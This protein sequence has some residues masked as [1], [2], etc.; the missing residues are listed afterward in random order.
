MASTAADFVANHSRR[1]NANGR[2]LGLLGGWLAITS[3]PF[4]FRNMRDCQKTVRP[5]PPPEVLI[6]QRWG[7]VHRVSPQGGLASQFMVYNGVRCRVQT[8]SIDHMSREI[9]TSSPEHCKCQWRIPPPPDRGRSLGLRG[10][11]QLSCKVGA[12]LVFCIN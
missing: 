10:K 9:H 3:K 4:I 7:C 1:Q 5:A 11:R 8:E 12:C 2:R 6:E